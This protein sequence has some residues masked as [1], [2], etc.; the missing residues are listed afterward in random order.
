MKINRKNYSVITQGIIQKGDIIGYYED[1]SFENAKEL[2]GEPVHY[3]N[4]WWKVLRLKSKLKEKITIWIVSGCDGGV[5][6][7]VY[8]AFPTRA[9]ARE[10]KSVYGGSIY[11]TFIEI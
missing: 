3:V 4:D 5:S 11:K 10:F 7:S 2:I 9:Y 1:G 6:D 8:Q